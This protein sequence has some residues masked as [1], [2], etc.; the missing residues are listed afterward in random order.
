[1]SA[2]TQ[3]PMD[4]SVV[5]ETLGH[6]MSVESM[7]VTQAYHSSLLATDPLIASNSL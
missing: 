2:L 7:V 4:S 6:V 1:M 3:H 5:M